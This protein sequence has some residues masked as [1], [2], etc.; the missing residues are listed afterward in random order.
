M[1]A[2]RMERSDRAPDMIW[3]VFSLAL[4]ARDFSMSYFPPTS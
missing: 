4:V 2:V 3:L 1:A